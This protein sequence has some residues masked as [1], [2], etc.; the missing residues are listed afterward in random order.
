[1]CL[2]KSFRVV[3][4]IGI[5]LGGTAIVWNL[6]SRRQEG[7]VIPE[8]EILS[9]DISRQTTQ[10]EYTE[11]KR[12]RTVF[13]VHAETST[14]T[15]SQV[16]TLEN[17]TLAYYDESGTVSDIISAQKAVYLLE[18]QQ[19]EFTGDARMKLADGTEVFSEQVSADLIQERMVIDGNFRFRKGDLRGDGES[20]IYD[21]P[22]RKIQVERGLHLMTASGSDDVDGR[23]SQAVYVLF[24]QTVE[25]LGDALIS[26]GDTHLEADQITVFLTREHR[27]EKIL[28]RGEARLQFASLKALSGPQINVFFNP[29]L[30]RLEKIEALGEPQRSSER[31]VYSEWAEGR[32]YFLEANRIDVVPE[33]EGTMEGLLLETFSARGDVLFRSPSLGIEESR[34]QEMEGQFFDNGEHLRQLDLRGQVFLRRGPDL[35]SSVEE[36][37]HSEVLT[38]RFGPEQEIEQA[39]ASGNVDLRLNSLQGYRHL[40]AR[41]S[42][43]VSY[44]DGSPERIVSRG[45]CRIEMGGAGQRDVLEAPFIEIRYRQG[46]LDHMTAQG[47]VTLESNGQ[48]ETRYTTSQRLEV[49]YRDSE[50]E[51]AVQ[52]GDFHFW[53]GN[54]ASIDVESDQA[55]FDPE[56]QK[57]TMTGERMPVLR[58]IGAAGSA[59]NS[60]VETT[61]QRLELDRRTGEITAL[62]RVRSFFPEEDGSTIITSGGMQANPET[63]WITYS[64]NPRITQQFNSITG[65]IVRYNHRDQQLVV[66]E[67][68]KSFLLEGNHEDGKKYT[69]QADRL[70]YKR[71]D[72][73]ARYEGKVRV[74]TDDLIVDAPFVEFIFLTADPDQLQEIVAW[75]GVQITGKDREAQ[76]QRAVHY[77]SQEKVVLTGDPAQVIEALRGKVTGRQLTF[78]TGDDRL[79]IEDPSTPAKP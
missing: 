75:G 37:L 63:G 73:R 6:L 38:L 47:G 1:M 79:L 28:S 35:Q 61:A 34:S 56:S 43:E 49:S 51:R 7:L 78:F 14:Q 32:D 60:P 77:P 68:V 52:S 55:V 71:A 15:V 4:I 39:I 62:G 8:V 41:D 9:P 58:F 12:G 44:L 19:I 59:D 29:D 64:V 22:Q 46:L 2:L 10:F 54:P 48:G 36:Q 27:I 25:L 26:G 45:D 72:L 21:F 53:E 18:D 23:A 33:R 76:G 42:V 24:E 74:K 31:A 70:L 13:T 3:L 40:R 65:K 17:V 16:H 50:M 20:L 30:K 66:E 69:V 5:L 67:E 57:I 11:H